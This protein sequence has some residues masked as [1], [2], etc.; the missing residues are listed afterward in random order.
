MILLPNT[1]IKKAG[2]IAE[3]LRVSFASIDFGEAH[4][5][6][7]SL[8]VAEMLPGEDA[9]TYCMRVDGA[10]Y[11]GKRNGKNQVVVC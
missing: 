4:S 6:T 11:Q 9:D 2:I 7:I 1:D 5:R 8:G 10:L 3:L